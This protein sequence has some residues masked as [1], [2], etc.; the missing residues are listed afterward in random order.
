M[1][2]CGKSYGPMRMVF[3]KNPD[4]HVGAGEAAQMVLEHGKVIAAS[5]N[6]A[7]ASSPLS[8]PKAGKD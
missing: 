8:Y 4:R 5:E 3:D 1:I 6:S 7:L 2:F